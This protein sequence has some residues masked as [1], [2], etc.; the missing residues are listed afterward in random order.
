MKVTDV[1]F[2]PYERKSLIGFADVTFDDELKVTGLAVFRRDGE[3]S[4]AM[5]RK[6]GKKKGE[7]YD[8]MYILE[9][10]LNKRLSNAIKKEVDKSPSSFEE[11]DDDDLPF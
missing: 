3:I 11:E 7:Y 9:D 6:K 5:P 4:V 1:K 2:N 10:D 8:I